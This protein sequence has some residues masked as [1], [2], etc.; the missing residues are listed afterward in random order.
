MKGLLLVCCAFF[1]VLN[2]SVYAQPVPDRQEPLQRQKETKKHDFHMFYGVTIMS[3]GVKED[4]ID[5][6]KGG[7][8]GLSVGFAYERLFGKH[9][10]LGFEAVPLSYNWYTFKNDGSFK[11]P[12]SLSHFKEGYRGNVG[13]LGGYLRFSANRYEEIA[14]FHID[15]GANLSIPYYYR[16]VQV[17][18]TGQYKI[19]NITSGLDTQ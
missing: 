11:Y 4:S 17:D 18:H 13:Q 7:S 2:I 9:F 15:F 16:Y 5:Y 10:A 19:K 6:Y 3:T 14:G 1:L 12:D 8:L